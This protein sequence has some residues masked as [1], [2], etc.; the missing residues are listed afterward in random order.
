LNHF[1]YFIL[2]FFQGYKVPTRR[3]VQ[4][5][6]KRLHHSHTKLLLNE[7]KNIDTL[8]VT[9]DLWSD[10]KLNSYMCLTG[11]FINTNSKLSSKVLSFTIFNE[12]H[13]GEQISYTIKK[14]LKRLQVYEKTCTITCDG[15]SNIRKSFKTLNPKR[16]HC[17]GHKLHLTVCNALCLWV[18]E[19]QADES[20]TTGEAGDESSDDV[21]AV[22][23]HSNNSRGKYQK[24]FLLSRNNTFL[25]NYLL[26]P[27]IFYFFLKI[28][29]MLPMNHRISNPMQLMMK[30]LQV[31]KIHQAMKI[32]I[33]LMIQVKCRILLMKIGKKVLMMMLPHLF[34]WNSTP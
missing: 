34:V 9:T 19:P 4:R 27:P 26:F 5:Q 25:L 23:N 31:M 22:A 15:A 1:Q 24:D 16:I 13:T 28:L 10:K 14:E 21:K 18:K 7:L 30:I 8:A 3:T 29:I 32:P 11:H 17:I 33:Y 12:R 2:I 20:S 6:L